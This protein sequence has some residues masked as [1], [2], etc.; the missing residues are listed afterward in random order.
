MQT[1]D[2]GADLVTNFISIS[3]AVMWTTVWMA[4][5]QAMRVALASNEM[6]TEFGRAPIRHI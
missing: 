1:G 3:I 4:E 2:T 6:P 5:L